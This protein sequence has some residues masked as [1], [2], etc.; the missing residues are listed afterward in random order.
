LT[1]P[2]IWS[3]PISGLYNLHITIGLCD[4]G[5][6]ENLPPGTAAQPACRQAG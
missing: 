6:F 4:I 5:E 2:M 1:Y 3:Q